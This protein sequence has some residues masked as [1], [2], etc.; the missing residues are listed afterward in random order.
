MTQLN[1][2]KLC[3]YEEKKHSR[4]YFSLNAILLMQ[5]KEEEAKYLARFFALLQHFSMKKIRVTNNSV[6]F[7]ITQL[8]YQRLRILPSKNNSLIKRD[9][10]KHIIYNETLL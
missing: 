5:Y 9:G 8:L 6:T 10:E 7:L 4:S 3:I 1:S 2:E